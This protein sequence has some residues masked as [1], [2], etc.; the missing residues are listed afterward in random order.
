MY[1]T[2]TNGRNRNLERWGRCIV[3]EKKSSNLLSENVVAIL[4]NKILNGEI[5]PGERIVE[6][7]IAAELGMSRGPIRE[8]MR[9][10]EQEGLVNY[11]P[12]KGWSMR[13]LSSEDAW[14][15]FYLR[16]SLEKLALQLCNGKLDDKSI[17]IME[18][19]VA[20]MQEAGQK[21][22]WVQVVENDELF[23]KEIIKA[24][25]MKRLLTMWNSMSGLN[26]AMFLTGKKANLFQI[27]AQHEHH[28]HM[29]QVLTE[30]NL[31]ESCKIVDEH[32][33]K[34]GKKLYKYYSMQENSL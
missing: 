27:D 33:L 23:H 10:I 12:N 14:E 11:I 21:N 5:S 22:N 24:S 29:L 26:F 3:E 18:E 7:D 1:V 19:A 34:T 28:T 6:A 31:E 15:V 2:R 17:F 20:K 8:A 32:Y 16:G 30:G 9:Q 4:R 13:V 25:R